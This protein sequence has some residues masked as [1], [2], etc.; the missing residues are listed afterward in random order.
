MSATEAKVSVRRMTRAD[1]DGILSIDRKIGGGRGIITYKDMVTLDPGGALD[2]SFVAEFEGRVVGFI[3]ARLSYVGVPFIE[4]A[5]IHAV[6]VD[7]EYRRQGIATRLLNTL[8]GHCHAEGI[9]RVRI[10]IDEAN[11]D[12]RRFF[13]RLGF[14][15]SEQ[16]NYVRT[17]EG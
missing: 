4:I 9:N 5:L 6:A 3:L 14:R 13:Q 16:A 7:P 17:F 11:T 15:R 12:L 2:L 1:I 8:L 10:V